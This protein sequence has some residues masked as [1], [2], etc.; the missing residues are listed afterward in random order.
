[1]LERLL[2]R[3][4]PLGISLL[5]GLI[6]CSGTANRS[7]DL[8][9]INGRVMDPESGLDAVRNVG[10]TDGSIVSL[11]D[12]PLAGQDTIDAAGL[13]VAP[14]FID[15]NTY[16]HGE[17]LFRLRA[18]DGVTSVLNLEDGAADVN[19]FYESL[20]GRALIHYGAAVDHETV[21][22]LAAGDSTIS[23]VDGVNEGRGLP[24]I[25]RRALTGREL[26]ALDSLVTTGLSE[27]AVALGFGINYT[28]GATHSEVLRLVQIAAAY[29][30][31]VHIHTRNFDRTRDWDELYEAFGLAI[32]TGARIHVKHVQST[33]GSYTQPAL[34]LIDKARSRTLEIS[35]ECYPYTAA[36]TF[37]ESAPYDDWQ[38]RP[39]EDFARYEWPPTGERLTRESFGRYR[40]EGGVFVIHPRDE[41]TQENA[42]RS[43]LAHPA[44]M[45]ASDGAWDNGQ[46]HPRVAGTNSRV[47]GRYVREEGVLSLMD[48]IRRMTL[49]PAQ[50]LEIRVPSMR[51]K[52]RVNVGAD[53]DIVVFDPHTVMDQAT[54]RDPLLAPRGIAAVLVL[55]VP[56]VRG[57]RLQDGTNP[58]QPIRGVE[59]N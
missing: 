18:A 50:H 51:D 19:A 43:C 29:D 39:D 30:A 1:V 26:D 45:V 42:V 55:G 31:P 15:L 3:N 38:S 47:L 28:P 7:H 5:L 57:G 16:Q 34:D 25:D 24:D 13:V 33:F 17:A 40:A 37:I 59:S 35:T 6:G 23:L 27:G 41:A 32:G 8:V 12:G 4:I 44:A 54:Y 36:A 46:T 56:V 9:I 52:G 58:G 2:K 48:A 53:A 11:T 22:H 21:R 49:L 10:I 14:G 20:A